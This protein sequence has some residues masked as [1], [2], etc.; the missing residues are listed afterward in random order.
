MLSVESELWDGRRFRIFEDG[1]TDP[2]GLP[3][4]TWHDAGVLHFT[5]LTC[6]FDH[7]GQCYFRARTREDNE[8]ELD[9]ILRPTALEEFLTSVDADFQRRIDEGY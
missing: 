4:L 2:T 3:I 8:R 6:P 5:D 9:Q 7:Q 1:T